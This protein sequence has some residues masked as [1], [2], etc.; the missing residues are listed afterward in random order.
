MITQ[1]LSSNSNHTRIAAIDGRTLGSGGGSG[2]GSVLSPFEKACTLSHIQAIHTLK[3]KP[4]EVFLVLE[5][6]VVVDMPPKAGDVKS[7]LY[8]A[9]PHWNIIQL[10]KIGRPSSSS[11]SSSPQQQ[12]IP[13]HR[14]L[15][16]SAAY[17]IS[18]QG[19]QTFCQKYPQHDDDSSLPN[20][21]NVADLFVFLSVPRVYSSQYNLV[22]TLD[23][24][25]TIHPSH[26]YQFHRPSNQ[27]EKQRLFRM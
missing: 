21:L 3:D 12:V 26:V 14:G 9:P 23:Q 19:V 8:S 7:I 11:S 6:D 18:R 16:S 10:H 22:S 2:S 25:S 17:L 15:H 27:Y 24:E 1:V 4:G 13:W 20:S 5:D